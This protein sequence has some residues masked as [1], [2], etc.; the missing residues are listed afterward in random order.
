MPEVV[1]TVGR[2]G[3]LRELG[4]GGMAVV[5]LARQVDLDR[6]VALKELAAFHAA[7]ADFARRF[8]RESRLAG[9]LVHPNVITVFDY[10]EHEGTPYIA[11]EYID[12]GSLRPYVG[13]MTLAQIGGV[14][15]G[16]LAGLA[17]AEQHQIVHRDLKPENLMVTNAGT[18][19]IADFGIAKATQAADTGAFVTA[20]GTT[21]GTPPYMAPE[22]AMAK[23]VGPWTD[24]YSVGCMAYEL[25]TGKP[26]FYDAEEPLA[27]LLR[28]ISEALPPAA[29]VADVDPEV[30]AWIER[31]TSK[32]PKDRPQ[33][34][35]VAW[36]EFEEI[37]IGKLGP[38]WRRDARLPA[39]EGPPADGPEAQRG[40]E[41]EEWN[42]VTPPP[43]PATPPPPSGP[44]PTMEG[45]DFEGT[46]P[47]TGD[48]LPS[49]EEP[50]YE[51]Y[52]PPPTGPPAI[53]EPERAP[54]AAVEPE[55]SATPAPEPAVEPEPS[56][57]PAP[58]PDA[59]ATT[60]PMPTPAPVQVAPP[61]PPERDEQP[62]PAGDLPVPPRVIVL[63]HAGALALLAALLIPLLTEQADRWNVFAVFSPFEAIGVGLAV[64]MVA[65]ALRAGRI[66]T[67]TAAGALIGFGGLTLVASIALLRFTI[68]RLDALSTVLAAVVFVG[69]AATLAAGL[70]CLHAS[71]RSGPI[72]AVDPGPLVL[73]LAGAGLAAVAIFTNYDGFSS[74]WSELPEGE[75]A[76][77]VFEPLLLVAAALLGVGLLGAQPGLA[78]GLLLATGTATCLHYLGVIVAAW[79][80]IGEVGEIHAAGFIGVAGGLLIVAAGAW[81]HRAG[82]TGRR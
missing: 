56:A 26:P 75:S 77:F 25:F 63:A 49:A 16:L 6:L 30:S 62:A 10:F 32:D 34:A 21:V 11:M 73:G 53:D 47:D 43:G 66:S 74:L 76:E 28:H 24:L 18:V 8:V 48:P 61:V 78:A 35:S 65:Q 2:Y 13:R 5:Y 79:R 46:G 42:T 45:I 40:G 4:R 64:W 52:L 12:R 38:R 7:D 9:S 71:S 41:S 82:A 17:E 59:A 51:T 39:P 57:T 80:A 14:L 19:K 58:E 81:A 22:Q 15:E 55:P 72:A 37:L 31:L 3:I 1:R 27:I 20:T 50:A 54:P 36:E 29:E 69:A 44:V 67:A 33:S 70:G 60:P 68:H 23:G